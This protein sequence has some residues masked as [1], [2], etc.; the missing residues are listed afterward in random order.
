[1]P[2]AAPA[3]PWPEHSTFDDQGLVVAGVSATELV[4]RFATP[5]IV[6]DAAELRGR[7]RRVRAAFP[8]ACY[9]VK[10]FTAHPA[11]RLALDEGL[12]LLAA[13]GGEVEACLRAGAPPS[14][15]VF[16]GNAKTDAE[17]E[18]AVDTGV[19]L[20]VADGLDE[21]RRLGSAAR[22]HGR[23]QRVLLRVVP[24]I[25]VATHE[26]IASRLRRVR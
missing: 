17:V 24:E 6:I 21:M 22:R 12:D 23:V 15:V 25:D 19:G 4:E 10:A 8:R 7:C 14:R 16:H 11:L 26:A 20:V 13:T 18:L 9:A 1:M 5:L 2:E 3:G